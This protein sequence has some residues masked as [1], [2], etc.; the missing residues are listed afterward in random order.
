MRV[1]GAND[2]SLQLAPIRLQPGQHRLQ[3]IGIAPANPT[4]DIRLGASGAQHL[5]EAVFKHNGA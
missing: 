2:D 1:V 4:L 3:I 5:A